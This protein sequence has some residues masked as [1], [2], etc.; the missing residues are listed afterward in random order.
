[1]KKNKVFTYL[2]IT[3]LLILNVMTLLNTTSLN[4]QIDAIEVGEGTQGEQGPKGDT[5]AQ[6]PVGEQ[7][8]KGDTGAQGS[9]GEQGPKG[10]TGAQ[11]PAGQ[12]GSVG[13]LASSLPYVSMGLALNETYQSLNLYEEITDQ[14]AYVQAKIAAGY[15]AV[16]NQEELSQLTRFTDNGLITVGYE[17]YVLTNDITLDPVTFTPIRYFSGV[18]DGAGF[19]ITYTYDQEVNLNLPQTFSVYIFESPY[20]ADF[21]NLNVVMTAVIDSNA[22]EYS[23]FIQYPEGF[24]RLVNVDVT[25]NAT[26]KPN[27]YPDLESYTDE[28]GAI[29]SK[30]D[31]D[32]GTFY[33]ER[34]SGFLKLDFVTNENI[35]EREVTEV[36]A[37]AGRIGDKNLVLVYDSEFSTDISGII[38]DMYEVGGSIGIN[39]EASVYFKGVISDL[40]LYIEGNKAI[41][42]YQIQVYGIGGAIGEAYDNTIFIV[43]QSVFLAYITFNLTAK[44]YDYLGEIYEIGGAIG[45]VQ[46]H[47]QIL[48]NNS[49]VRMDFVLTFQSDNTSTESYDIDIFDIGGVIGTLDNNASSAVFR[50]SISDTYISIENY[51]QNPN[52]RAQFNLNSIAGFV[53]GLSNEEYINMYVIDSLVA[54]EFNLYEDVTEST[55]FDVND[56][57]IVLGNSYRG[58]NILDNVYAHSANFIVEGIDGSG[59][60][61]YTKITILEEFDFYSINPSTFVFKDDWD[62]NNDWAY[63]VGEG[64]ALFPRAIALLFVEDGAQIFDGTLP[65]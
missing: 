27:L 20:R 51:S 37:L 17:Q 10:D 23:A 25:F 5:G 13:N 58:A 38:K 45:N 43:E 40:N 55:L 36:G 53:G 33:L 62:F 1:M 14:A 26:I 12:S 42:E 16:S 30:I 2:V 48:I 61:Y 44:D 57:G 21:F 8:P 60:N 34:T 54:L 24:I 65:E 31:D 3:F 28:V 64:F 9:V 22:L 18:L 7:G 41:D 15:I 63:L 11:G 59:W 52:S 35:K 46:S 19:T 56:V 49:L 29:F 6:G 4:D 39:S 47:P 32:K 50:Q